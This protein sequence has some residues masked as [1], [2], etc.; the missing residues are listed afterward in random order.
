MSC[1]TY[2]R[3]SIY[4]VCKVVYKGGTIMYVMSVWCTNYGNI[5][6]VVYKLMSCTRA[7]ASAS[8]PSRAA[9]RYYYYY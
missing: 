1:I 6:G 8:P 2:N 3:V 4:V 9:G 7:S 5:Y